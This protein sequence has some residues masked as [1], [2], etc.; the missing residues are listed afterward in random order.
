MGCSA[1]MFFA[2]SPT[3]GPVLGD[4]M[5]A[6]VCHSFKIKMF[7]FMNGISHQKPSMVYE[8]NYNRNV[9]HVFCWLSIAMVIDEVLI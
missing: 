1:E 8:G 4:R 3:G 6:E 2:I 5:F 7:G 9:A